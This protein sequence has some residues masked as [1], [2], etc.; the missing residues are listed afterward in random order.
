MGQELL[1]IKGRE[2]LAVFGKKFIVFN[3][4]RICCGRYKQFKF[5]FEFL[6]TFIFKVV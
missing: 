6:K 5:F 2:D 3:H 1:R 4:H